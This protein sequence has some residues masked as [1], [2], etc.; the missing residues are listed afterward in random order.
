LVL[1]AQLKDTYMITDTQNIRDLR[2]WLCWHSETRE[3]KPTKIPYSPH[4]S[5]RA[6]STDPETWGSY[7]EA[8][9]ACKKHGYGGIGFVFTAEDDLCGVDLDGCLDPE[10]GEIEDWAQEM[11]EELNSYAEISP[12]GTGIHVL[13]RGKLPSG[14]NR[15]GRFEAYDRGRYFTVTG[16]HLAGTP[17]TIESRQ[18]QL[19]RVVQRVF[20][21]SAA[22]SENGH[23][24]NGSAPKPNGLADDALIQKALSASNGERFSRLWSGDTSGYGSHS[25]ADLALCGMLAFWTG[26]DPI[27]M[28]LLFRASG[29]YREKWE[30]ADYREGTISEALDGKTEFYQPSTTVRLK[31][32]TEKDGSEEKEERRN[33][34]DRL[35]GYALEDVSGTRRVLW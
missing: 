32:S 13:V 10:T 18:E 21:S 11:I 6:S 31:D 5:V 26:G 14:R 7:Q 15:K 22:E 3:G 28:D 23:G 33:Q 27:R 16:R 35:I 19:E 2:Q 4:T 30:R 20:G 9:A 29:L 25:E 12:S 1:P 24:T 8:V 34:A 17:Q